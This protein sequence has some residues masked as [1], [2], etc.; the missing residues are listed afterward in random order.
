MRSCG[1]THTRA[2]IADRLHMDQPMVGKNFSLVL[3]CVSIL[4]D[5]CLKPCAVRCSRALDR[6]GCRRARGHGGHRRA[7]ISLLWR[8]LP[9]DE[10]TSRVQ[11]AQRTICKTPVGAKRR[12]CW[13]RNAIR[14]IKYQKDARKTAVVA[15]WSP[16]PRQRGWA[17]RVKA[18]RW[19]RIITL[20]SRRA[21]PSNVTLRWLLPA[22]R[23]NRHKCRTQWHS[24]I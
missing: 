23:Q 5:Y 2:H 11:H 20:L 13:R 3:Q 19:R 1:P 15:R 7:L 16:Q 10:I 4:C 22:T 14:P 8:P 21:P 12:S 18:S 6:W 9:N 17:A 24:Q